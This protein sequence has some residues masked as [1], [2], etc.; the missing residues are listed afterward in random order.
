MESFTWVMPTQDKGL[1][2]ILFR[3]PFLPAP[4]GPADGRIEQ[5]TEQGTRCVNEDVGYQSGPLRNEGLV[6]F[7]TGGVEEGEQQC[8]SSPFTPFD[9]LP[10]SE[11]EQLKENEVFG[12]VSGFADKYEGIIPE[13]GHEVNPV[14]GQGFDDKTAK[15]AGTAS[16]LMGHHEDEYHHENG[17]DPSKN[18]LSW[19]G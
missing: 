13:N 19:G 17:W 6:E 15:P 2:S 11:E 4:S 12:K 10:Q 18:L 16:F 14:F 5:Q 8:C 9:P 7:V 1:H 3:L